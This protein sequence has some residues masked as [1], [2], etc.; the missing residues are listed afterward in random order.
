MTDKLKQVKLMTLAMQKYPWEHGVVAQAFLEC[1][2]E[3][4]TICLAREAVH[5]QIDDGR[6]AMIGDNITVT[7][8][9]VTGEPIFFAYEKTGD[10]IFKKSLEKLDE[11]VMK[12]APRSADGILYHVM[13]KPE[14]WVDSVYMLPPYLAVT[15]KYEEAIKQI[16]GYWDALFIP[17]KN[18]LG[19]MY[20]EKE[21]AFIRSDVWGV[22]N[23]WALA[24]IMRAILTLPENMESEKECLV[25]KVKTLLDGAL[26]YMR[27]DGFFHDV[28]DDPETFIE[29]NF[30]Q[31]MAYTIYKGLAA[32]LLDED[33]YLRA[34]DKMR[35]AANTK[36]DRY[37]MVAGVCG[38]PSFDRSGYASEGQAFYILME[39]ASDKYKR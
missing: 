20:N 18:L 24:G 28:L 4:E 9:V 19:H 36:V 22:G 37:G 39:T 33:H 31:M 29:T 1:G 34:A 38:A 25:K 3:D 7:D 15:G 12:T 26:P 11:W 23:G 17:E 27:E 14:F 2:D 10:P 5:R 32:G 21:K 8:P 35:A 13:D 6:P 30:P 16:N